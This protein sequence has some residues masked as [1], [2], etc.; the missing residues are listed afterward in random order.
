M[1]A[2]ETADAIVAL[3]DNTT[4]TLSAIATKMASAVDVKERMVALTGLATLIADGVCDHKQQVVGLWLIYSEFRTIPLSDHPF[5]PIFLYLYELRKSA[6]HACPRQIFDM[7]CTFFANS[8]TEQF[9]DHSIRTI[10]SERYSFVAPKTV[11]FVATKPA[12]VR[13]SP[14]LAWECESSDSMPLSEVIAQLLCE[15]EIYDDFGPPVACPVP[16]VCAVFPGE[17]DGSYLSSYEH[18][19]FLFMSSGSGMAEEHEP[20]SDAV[21]QELPA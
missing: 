12:D 11:E 7:I 3:L 17:L 21:V 6:V 9:A 20:K 14:V 13:M 15:S 18:P 5:L 2:R 1:L 16:E 10:F 4:D 19:P 8:G